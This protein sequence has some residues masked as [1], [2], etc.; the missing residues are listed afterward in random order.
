MTDRNNN[1]KNAIQFILGD[2]A[3]LEQLA[4][5]RPYLPFADETLAFLDTFYQALREKNKTLQAADIAALAFWCRKSNLNHIRAAY[6]TKWQN[7]V[8]VGKGVTF[9]I[10]PSNMPVLFAFS[11]A[12]ALLAGNPVVL[13]LP[14]KETAQEQMIAAALEEAMETCPEWRQRIVF[15]RYGHE[16]EVTD[17][18]SQLCQVRVIWGGDHS[19]R[20]IQKS[21]L[22]PGKTELAFADRRSAAVFSTESV[23]TAG[24]TELADLIRGFY[25]DTYLNDQN[26]C[27]SPSLI[28]WLGEAA[29]VQ[30][31]RERFWQAAAA[32]I[33]KNYAIGAHLAVRKWEQA[34]Y[35]AAQYPDMTIRK[36]GNEIVLVQ[37]PQLYAD[38]WE[39]TVPGGFFFES[40]GTDLEGLYPVL[41][42]KC[43][44]LTC[45]GVKKEMLAGNLASAGVCGVDCIVEIGHA[46]DFSLIWDGMDLMEYLT[47]KINVA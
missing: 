6:Q 5:Q 38:L 42:R 7:T 25:N 9:H 4:R 30:C 17:A 34:L 41:T 23:L 26:A 40:S 3:V 24:D 22:D 29:E 46:L 43:Q 33:Q 37:I 35:L 8:V 19:I 47:R 21:V 31:A 39:Q 14:E 10:V 16:K 18:L 15:V 12:A 45:V 20:E 44:T 11:M 2:A 36:Y 32:Y 1:W 27:S 13:R 28:Y